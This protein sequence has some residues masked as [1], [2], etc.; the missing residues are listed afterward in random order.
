MEVVQE[1][2][3]EDPVEGKNED[4]PSHPADG[5]TDESEPVDRTE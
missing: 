3:E 2:A 5:E 4:A 1:Q